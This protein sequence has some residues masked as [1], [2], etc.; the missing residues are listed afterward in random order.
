MFGK[1]KYSRIIQEFL[2]AGY[3]FKSFSS[4]G[5]SKTVYLRHDID[6]SVRDAHS[7]A[8]E[9]EKLGIQSTYFFMLTSN[10]YNLM[11]ESNRTLVEEI[12]NLGHT[13]S[14]HFDP[15]AYQDLDEGF[16]IEKNTFN[17]VFDVEI[18]VVSIHRP[19]DFL[20]NN[21]RKLHGCLHTY[22][23]RFFKEMNYISDS[24]GRDI[25]EKLKEMAASE[26]EK[27]LHLL[28]HPIWW[29]SNTESPTETLNDWLGRNSDFLIE[30]TRRN[31]KTFTG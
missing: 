21:N 8:L 7:I 24:G 4:P 11:S 23:D 31:C 12:K 10:T 28:L 26:L 29:A 22:E 1:E 2:E 16:L 6:F 25:S 27:P 14:L 15:V 20:I 3:S 13:V 5:D 30:E 18:D 9:E 17:R 19:G